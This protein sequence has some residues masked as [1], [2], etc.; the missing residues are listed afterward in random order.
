MAS[1]DLTASTPVFSATETALD[2]AVSA[3]NL[4]A[5]TDHLVVI[6]WNN[7]ALSFKVEREA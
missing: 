4:A 7:G 3:L 5:V 1:G 6:P 2:T